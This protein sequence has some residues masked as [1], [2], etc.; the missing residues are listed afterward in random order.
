[1]QLNILDAIAEKEAGIQQA[2][3][4]ANAVTPQWSDKAYDF[5]VRY[6][7]SATSSFMC[8]DVRHKAEQAGFPEPP[9]NR[10][11]GAVLIRAA[12]TGLIRNIG[13]APTKNVKAHRAFASLWERA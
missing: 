6:V 10:A 3:D 4:H 8:E 13:A 1:M 11:W 12:K 7:S 5:L 9:H 2:V